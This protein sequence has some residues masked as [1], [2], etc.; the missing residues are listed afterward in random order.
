MVVVFVVVGKI[1]LY[2]LANVVAGIAEV[3]GAI[4]FVS[5]VASDGVVKGKAVAEAVVFVGIVVGTILVEEIPSA[6]V[7][8]VVITVVSLMVEVVGPLVTK[9]IDT[10]GA[11]VEAMV[12]FG[13]VEVVDVAGT[14]VI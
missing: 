11:E 14:V 3:L 6:V 9:L 12:A 10:V 7:E 2:M 8:V 4:Y 5:V 1:V 13:M